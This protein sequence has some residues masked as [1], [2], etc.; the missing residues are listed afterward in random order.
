MYNIPAEFSLAFSGAQ[1]C[2]GTFGRGRAARRARGG[3]WA[4]AFPETT[5][6]SQLTPSYN[7]SGLK[8]KLIPNSIIVSHSPSLLRAL[9]SF[10]PAQ[11]ERNFWKYKT[12]FSHF[13]NWELWAFPGIQLFPVDVRFIP[14]HFEVWDFKNKYL[15]TATAFPL[16]PFCPLA[17]IVATQ[18][19]FP[20]CSI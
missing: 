14:P 7:L 12:I 8:W 20:F 19:S 6:R 4:R 11:L 17:C 1:G 5:P 13:P 15:P 16:I 2:L 10:H 18:Q 3:A 9:T